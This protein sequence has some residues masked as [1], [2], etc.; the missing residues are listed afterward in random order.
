ML[1]LNKGVYYGLDT[2]GARI[3]ELIQTPQPVVAVRDAIV[4]EYDVTLERCEHDLLAL[5]SEL[6]AVALIELRDA[7]AA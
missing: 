4:R 5:L 3:W 1:D 7:P 6:A 2:V